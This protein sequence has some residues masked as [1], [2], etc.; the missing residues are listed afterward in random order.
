MRRFLAAL[1]ILSA[2]TV[3][4]LTDADFSAHFAEAVGYGMPADGLLLVVDVSTQTL[5]VVEAGKPAERRL[6]STALAGVGNA[7]GSNQTPL[8]WHRVEERIGDGEPLGRVFKSR[9]PQAEILPRDQLT[10]PES[11]DYVLTRILWLRGLQPGYNSGAGVDSHER[12]IYFHGTNQEQLLGTPASHG[13]IRL[14]NDDVIEL[15]DRVKAREAW[16]LIVD[17]LPETERISARD[18]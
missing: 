10:A 5:T 17:K 15:F 13:C 11:G 4:A 14:S 6:V 7:A 2:M 18:R 12:C 8:G 1:T 3:S 9:Q 16:C